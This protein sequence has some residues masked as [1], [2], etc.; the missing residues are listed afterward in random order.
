MF[1]VNKIKKKKT[2]NKQIVC[3]TSHYHT[4]LNYAKFKR[5]ELPPFLTMISV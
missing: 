1:F 3:N 5:N 2:P 4:K